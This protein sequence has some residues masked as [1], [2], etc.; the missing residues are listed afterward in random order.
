MP[1]QRKT[2][3]GAPAQP[4]TPVAGQTYGMGVQQQ[5]LAEA[6]PAP[7][8]APAPSAAPQV[9]PSQA[10]VP[11]PSPSAAAPADP[12]AAALAM[13]DKVGMLV[14]PTERPGEPWTH[15]LP[16]GPGGGP[17]VLGLRQPSPLGQSLR[18]LSRITGDPL[19]GQLAD[20]AGL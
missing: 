9:Q 17:E 6:M 8:A 20:R 2:Q 16:G 12:M 19:M 4:S 13:R 7:Q 1:R 15:G 3:S 10:P 11:A 5:R 18:D 14:P